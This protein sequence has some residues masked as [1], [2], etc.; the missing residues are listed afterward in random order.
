MS[1][2][3]REVI[4]DNNKREVISNNKNNKNVYIQTISKQIV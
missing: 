1:H 4:I 2:E 3:K